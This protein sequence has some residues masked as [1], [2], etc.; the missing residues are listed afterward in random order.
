MIA[1]GEN[2]SVGAVPCLVEILSERPADYWNH[3]YACEALARIRFRGAIPALRN[4]MRSQ[5]FY[6][7]PDAF[8]A[9]LTLGD[10]E[11]VPLAIARVE[12]QLKDYN[13]GYIVKEL[14]RVTGRNYGFNQRGWTSWWQCAGRGWQIPDKFQKPYDEQPPIY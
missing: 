12:P 8:R 9:L 1:L 5:D 2:R 10:R 11:A 6:A 4:C 14:E 7:L 3:A 13:S